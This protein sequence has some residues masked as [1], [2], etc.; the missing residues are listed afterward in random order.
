MSK[1]V[2]KKLG[3]DSPVPLSFFRVGNIT[4]WIG[5]NEKSHG[6]YKKRFYATVAGGS[7]GGNG[8]RG[9]IVCYKIQFL[10]MLFR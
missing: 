10:T 5:L 9:D 1:E 6:R 2:D 4:A 8:G 7:G 3:I